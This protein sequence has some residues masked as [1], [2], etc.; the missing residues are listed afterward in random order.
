MRR[1]SSGACC[2]AAAHCAPATSRPSGSALSAADEAG[3]F[4]SALGWTQWQGPTYALT[5]QGVVRTEEDDDG[6]FVLPLTA[7]VDVSGALTCDW[8]DGDVW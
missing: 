1:W 3:E 5:P 7:P 4:Y 2:T 8:R 6:V